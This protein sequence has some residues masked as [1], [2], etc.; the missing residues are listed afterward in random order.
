MKPLNRV[1]SRSFYSPDET[2]NFKAHGHLDILNFSEGRS[3][4]LATFETGWKWS[5]DVKPIAGTDS[6]E[7]DHLGYCVSGEMIIRMNN[8]DEVR[9]KQGD[10]YEIPP[11]HDAWVVGSQPCVLLDVLGNKSYAL[12]KAA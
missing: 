8:G 5:N 1:Q 11:G 2:R 6:C 10:V 9:I 4:G 12:P 7:V 3:I